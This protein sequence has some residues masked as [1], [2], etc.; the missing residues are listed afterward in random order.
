MSDL[1]KNFMEAALERFHLEKLAEKEQND[2][3]KNIGTRYVDV[4]LND[5]DVCAKYQGESLVKQAVLHC[6]HAGIIIALYEISEENYEL[7]EKTFA[8]LT[9]MDT[10]FFS[11]V[12]YSRWQPKKRYAKY[13]TDFMA[14]SLWKVFCY[15]AKEQGKDVNDPE[16][17]KEGLA[18]LF[19]AGAA[20]DLP[21]MEDPYND[22]SGIE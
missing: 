1:K 15:V 6:Y 2:E 4:F 9:N 17:F 8:V 20:A 13:K 3:L 16:V 21:T 22:L 18:L 10:L 5:E 19:L 11:S 14:E 7:S 12:M